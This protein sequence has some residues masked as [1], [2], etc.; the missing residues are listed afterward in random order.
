MQL[1]VNES[2]LN[3]E[4]R[5]EKKLQ[6]LT[7]NIVG[8]VTCCLRELNSRSLLLTFLGNFPHKISTSP[9]HVVQ[10]FLL[11]MKDLFSRCLIKE[12]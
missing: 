1:Y 11:Q 6:V 8:H 4:I 7:V 5:I 2:C 10:L 3:K 9:F 12:K